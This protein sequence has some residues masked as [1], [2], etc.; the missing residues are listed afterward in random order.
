MSQ[1]KL[2]WEII[3]LDRDDDDR[4]SFTSFVILQWLCS[5]V[6]LDFKVLLVSL[7]SLALSRKAHLFILNLLLCLDGTQCERDE[8][9]GR[10]KAF[11]HLLHL[12]VAI[13]TIRI[14][15]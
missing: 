2:N 10:E 12:Q 8:E 5:Q 7:V 9:Q 11:G 6:S 15:F 4:N 1:C 14:S 3:V 13:F